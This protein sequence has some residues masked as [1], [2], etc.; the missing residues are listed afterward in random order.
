MQYSSLRYLSYKTVP[1]LVVVAPLGPPHKNIGK[2]GL[3]VRRGYLCSEV[4][5]QFQHT[6][7][8]EQKM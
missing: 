6:T 5:P 3:G 1:S 7:P 4:W 2:S 8:N